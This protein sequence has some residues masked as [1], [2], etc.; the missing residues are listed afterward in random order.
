MCSSKF[1]ALSLITV[2]CGWPICA[3]FERRQSIAASRSKPKL[4]VVLG[5]CAWSPTL[6]V[7]ARSH[8]V[9]DHYAGSPVV[10]AYSASAFQSTST[11]VGP[12]RLV[13]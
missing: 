3:P 5:V 1:D 2:E 7:Y 8:Y 6:G 13:S 12:F 4:M 11:M 9:S 10:G